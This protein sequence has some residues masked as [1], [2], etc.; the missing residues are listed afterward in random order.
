LQRLLHA[1][2]LLRNGDCFIHRYGQGLYEQALGDA[3]WF[4]FEMLGKLMPVAY[5]L[6]REPTDGSEREP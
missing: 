4:P 2:R 1:A 3:Q 5:L 6:R